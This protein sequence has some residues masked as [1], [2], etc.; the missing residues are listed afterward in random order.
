MPTPKRH[1]AN[2]KWARPT[3]ETPLPVWLE[4]EDRPWTCVREDLRPLE[5]TEACEDCPHWEERTG[6]DE[7]GT[8]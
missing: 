5:S 7:D 3:L 8:A 4:V 2:C 1:A 6:S